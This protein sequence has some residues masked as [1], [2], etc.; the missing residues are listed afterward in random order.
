MAYDGQARR[1]DDLPPNAQGFLIS[2]RDRLE[3]M[4]EA[5]SKVVTVRE[6]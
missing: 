2:N 6:V 5:E 4:S 3:R 1:L